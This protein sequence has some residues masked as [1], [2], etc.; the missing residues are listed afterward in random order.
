MD[1]ATR[2]PP[3]RSVFSLAVLLLLVLAVTAQLITGF[4]LAFRPGTTLL[5]V[6]IAGGV[7]A[8][9]FTVAEWSWLCATRAGRYRLGKFVAADSGPAEWSEAAFLLVATATVAL[10]ALLAAMM[11]ARTGFPFG[12]IFAAHRTLAVAVAVLYVA[13]SLLSM[14][15]S[16]SRRGTG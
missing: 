5:A 13:H 3:A 8:L 1:H 14:H 16:R 15:R 12:P 9:V 7:A 4:L 11:H 10:G 6:H 2:S